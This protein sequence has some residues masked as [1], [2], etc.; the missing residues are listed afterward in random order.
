MVGEQDAQLPN[1]EKERLERV[2]ARQRLLEEKSASRQQRVEVTSIILSCVLFSQEMP[3]SGACWP[4]NR[5]PAVSER[6]WRGAAGQEGRNR[7]PLMDTC[8]PDLPR[9]SWA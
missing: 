3:L 2:A 5:R 6:G 7:S 8:M 4:C 1:K 9:P